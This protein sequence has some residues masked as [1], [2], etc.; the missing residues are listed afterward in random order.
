M[1]WAWTG[2][3]RQQAEIEEKGSGKKEKKKIHEKRQG[4][5]IVYHV[6]MAS[7]ALMCTDNVSWT[8]VR[9]LPGWEAPKTGRR[10]PL[11]LW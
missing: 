4:V 11:L 8:P 9:T 1:C 7:S 6:T 5:E 10:G 3:E 2:I